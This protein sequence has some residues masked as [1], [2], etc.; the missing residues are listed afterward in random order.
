MHVYG[1]ICLSVLGSSVLLILIVLEVHPSGQT[2]ETECG[3]GGAARTAKAITV[4]H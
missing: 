4:E 1:I 3:V 2:A